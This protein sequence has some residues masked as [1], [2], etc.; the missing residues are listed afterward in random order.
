MVRRVVLASA[1]LSLALGL[2]GG[3]D[4]AMALPCDKSGAHAEGRPRIG[5]V[6]GG[7]GA[8]GAAHVGVLKVLEELHIPVDCI[9]GNSMG[10]IVGGLYASGLS[11][12]D[13]EREM[14]GMDWDD[15]LDDKPRRPDQ[16][17]RRKRDDDNY[18][19]KKYVGISGKGLELPLGYIQG[20]KFDMELARLTHHVSGLKTFDELPIPFRAVATDIETGKVVVLEKGNLARAI[21]AS[22]AVPGAFDPVDIDGKLLVD[23]LVANNV[24]VDIGRAM[25]A[26]LLIVVDVGT[27]LMK[28]GE[29]TTALSVMSQMS[30]I[31]SARNVELQLATL[32]EHDVYIRPEL[33]DLQTSDFKRAADAIAV[34]AAA[35]EGRREALARMAL[36]EPGRLPGAQAT[37]PDRQVAAGAPAP[38]PGR[39]RREGLFDA[40]NRAHHPELKVRRPAL[41]NPVTIAFVEIDN[42]SPISDKVLIQPFQALL[43]KPL[44]Y[45]E[46]RTA[47][48]ELYGWNT[49]ESVRY[50]VI[51]RDGEAGLKLHVKEK[52]WGPN[53][54]QMG[55]VVSTDFDGD[56]LWN[57]GVSVLKTGMNPYAGEARL[58]A[59][60]GD[61]PSVF[62]EFYQ[63]IGKSLR[64]FI[65]PQLIYDARDIWRFE[66]DDAIEEYRVQRYGG[67]LAGGRVLGRWGEIR[68]G[69]Q[70]YLGDV[71]ARVGDPRILDTDI[72]AA[73]A[74]LRLTYD[75]FDNRNWPR[76]GALGTWTWTESI[77]SLGAD[78]D[79][80][81]SEMRFG[82]ARSWGESTMLLAGQFSYTAS[83]RAPVQNRARGGGLFNLSG[84]VQDQ[85]SGQHEVL[86]AAAFYRRLGAAAWLPVFAGLSLEYGNVYEDR[87][88]I[89]LAPD[90]ALL[91]GSAFLGVDTLL[92]PVYLGYGHAE[93]GQ[94]AL[95]LFL[96]RLF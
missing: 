81:Q 60:I 19:I 68:L 90:D 91:A 29:I 20:Q 46:L 7:G 40:G 45:A 14:V 64:Y 17:F 77:E 83:G 25:G 79:F 96:G 5:L 88:D 16:Q 6:L 34:G 80:A 30:N 23:G 44:D 69:L 76:A 66:G 52:A 12:A 57:V 61:S 35:A 10:A 47:V 95:Y 43:G 36:L 9:A 48:E 41:E 94:N 74:Y 73:E 15:V 13:I 3:M 49:F 78:T 54:V 71:E 26:D 22:M 27:P 53:Y 31:L 65:V 89:S 42:Q 37:R 11:P 86:M 39:R 85:L 84:F 59:Q 93:G 18:L 72:D 87:S 51:D 32:T 75:T 1:G 24:P 8:R 50:E 70:R 55:M 62:G 56:S 33:G 67:A 2:M 4:E 63:P 28:R 82:W 21:R 58:A 38:A 92:G